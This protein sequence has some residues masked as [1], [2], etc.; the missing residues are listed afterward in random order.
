MHTTASSYS[1]K[2]IDLFRNS[3]STLEYELVCKPNFDVAVSQIRV[4]N[5][6]VIDS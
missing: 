2:H 1:I 5:K 6:Y 3:R 4:V